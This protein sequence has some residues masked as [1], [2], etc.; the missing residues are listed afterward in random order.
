MSNDKE[1]RQFEKLV[2]RIERILAPKGAIVKSPD[3]VQDILTGSLREVD[4]SIRIKVG[5][6]SILITVE[7][8]KRSAVQDDTWIEQLATKKEK[9]GAAKTIAVSASGFSEPAKITA[10]LKGIELRTVEEVN[11]ED[12]ISWLK[13]IILVHKIFQIKLKSISAKLDDDTTTVY[14]FQREEPNGSI[15]ALIRVEDKQ[16]VSPYDILNLVLTENST[17]I[18]NVRSDG[19]KEFR[20]LSA[21]L[22]KGTMQVQADE[23][24]QLITSISYELECWYETKTEVLSDGVRYKYKDS[25]SMIA[26]GVEFRTEIG[27][28]PIIIGLAIQGEPKE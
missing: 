8:R 12:I 17:D 16:Y 5:S 28:I 7:C 23:G 14:K 10:Q 26:Q 15:R 25:E 21:K 13:S 2:A 9:I 27:E 1:W 20:I 6:V 3:K 19:N 11:D 4:A 22:P 24:S 18:L